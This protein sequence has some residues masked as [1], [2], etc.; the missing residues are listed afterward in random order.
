[1]TPDARER[2]MRGAKG[3][4]A[5]LVLGGVAGS[6]AAAQPSETTRCCF[7]NWRYAGGCV[8]QV[9]EDES[10]LDVLS[11]LNNPMSTTPGYCRE[12]DVR[13][14]WVQV[15]CEHPP[16]GV[17][18][19]APTRLGAE[20]PPTESAPTERKER[21]GVEEPGPGLRAQRPTYITPVEPHALTPR[22]PADIVLGPTSFPGW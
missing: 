1:M 6:A 2:M 3:L 12:T 11:V 14:G 10:C 20:E 21:L 8:V 4:L 19:G 9:P 22:E 13:G 15:S 17:Y 7:A 16:G 18:A 5:A